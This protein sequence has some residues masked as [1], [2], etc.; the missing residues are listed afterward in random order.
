M[1]DI[2]L[3]PFSLLSISADVRMLFFTYMLLAIH[4]SGCKGNLSAKEL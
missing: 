3:P 4:S 1:C 2:I